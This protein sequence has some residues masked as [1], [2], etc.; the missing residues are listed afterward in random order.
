[1]GRIFLPNGQ[2]LELSGVTPDFQF[3]ARKSSL[4]PTYS[5]AFRSETIKPFLTES[6][7]KQKAYRWSSKI[8]D[9]DVVPDETELLQI[10]A[11]TV[12]KAAAEN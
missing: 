11:D 5:Y 10:T 7:S 3:A 9:P 2:A 8:F 12:S 4:R 6:T 1:M